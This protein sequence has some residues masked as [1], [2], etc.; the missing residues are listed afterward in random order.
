MRC[1]LTQTGRQGW[2]LQTPEKLQAHTRS[3]T[4]RPG[5]PGKLS[6]ALVLDLP[7]TVDL[8]QAGDALPWRQSDILGGAGALAETALDAVVHQG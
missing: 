2:D 7:Q 5:A 6:R 8:P 1:H 4:A 3:V